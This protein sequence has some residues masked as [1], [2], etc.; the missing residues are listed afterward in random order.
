QARTGTSPK[1]RTGTSP[2]ARTGTSPQARTGTS[3]GADPCVASPNRGARTDVN[4][5]PGAG[6]GTAE[7]REVGLGGRVD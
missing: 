3:A 4:S 5:G 6:T 1:A 7:A 2:Q